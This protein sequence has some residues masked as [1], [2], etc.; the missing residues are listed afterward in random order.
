MKKKG[1]G[2][3][4]VFLALIMMTVSCSSEDRCFTC[5]LNATTEIICESN[6]EMIAAT[7]GAEVDNL[8]DFIN[9]ITPTGFVC[10]EVE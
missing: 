1:F 2:F 3:S 10:T 7:T 9:L 5:T 6:F 8:D 4:I